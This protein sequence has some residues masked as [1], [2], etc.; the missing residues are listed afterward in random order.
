MCLLVS[1]YLCILAKSL[2]KGLNLFLTYLIS[3]HSNQ[4]FPQEHSPE[5]IR[6]EGEAE[7]HDERK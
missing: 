7:M 3:A 6:E 4:S 1:V 5:L 2:W